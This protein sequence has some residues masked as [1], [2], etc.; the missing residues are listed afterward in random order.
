MPSSRLV[1]L[2]L[3]ALALAG[4][5]VGDDG[6]RTSETRDVEPFSRVDNRDSVDVRLRVGEPLSVRVLAGEKVIDDVHTEVSDGTLKLEYSGG[7]GGVGRMGGRGC[8]CS[9]RWRDRWCW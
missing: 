4:C 8:R 7:G 3:P 5:A 6:P 1:L 9:F 2:L